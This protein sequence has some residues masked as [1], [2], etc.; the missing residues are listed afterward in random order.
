MWFDHFEDTI[1]WNLLQ[2][3]LSWYWF[4]LF[5]VLANTYIHM[6]NFMLLN[7]FNHNS[8]IYLVVFAANR[9]PK[10]HSMREKGRIW[11]VAQTNIKFNITNYRRISILFYQRSLKSLCIIVLYRLWTAVN[12]W[13]IT[14]LASDKDFR[15]TWRYSIS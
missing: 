3:T 10:T 4:T 1:N 5:K 8:R 6:N 9:L 14:N 12:Y 7:I 2:W 11:P 13:V 15:H